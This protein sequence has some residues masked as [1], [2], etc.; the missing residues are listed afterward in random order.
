MAKNKWRCWLSLF[1]FYACGGTSI[2]QTSTSLEHSQWPASSVLDFSF[3]VGDESQDYDI[4]LLV[5]NSQDYPYQNL[6]VTY[7]LE[8]ATHNL[9]HKELKNY[10]LFDIKTGKPL[11]TGWR[12]S[13]RH[14][15][16][17]T[18]GYQ[19]S[20]SGSYTLKL[21]HFMR[22]DHLPGLQTIGM[23]VTPSK[24]HPDETS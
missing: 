3:Q 23:K 13:K 5:K 20:Q 11:G 10:A 8:D 21:V 14:E 1:L 6:Y 7:Y 4:Y 17:L 9:L 2:Y 22:T 24:L 18:T 12:K 15:F 16:L 19:F